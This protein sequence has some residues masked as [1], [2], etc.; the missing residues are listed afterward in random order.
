MNTGARYGEDE[1]RV[2]AA[3]K[4]AEFEKSFR[5]P[6][7]Y[8][9]KNH[10]IAGNHNAKA[11]VVVFSDP[12]CVFCIKNVP[13][14]IES[15]KGRD[16]IALYYYDFPLDMH[17]TAKTVIKAIVKAKK[18]GI[19]DVELKVYKANYEKFYNVYNTKEPQKAL[20]VFNKIFST[21]YTLE[22]IDTPEATEHIESDIFRGME[23]NVQGTPTVA[24]NG[25]FKDSRKNLKNFL[26]K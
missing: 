18:D 6:N 3:K 10:L 16:D 11:K 25:S 24:F 1:Q 20:D 22:Q 23:A 26:D 17:P 9:A 19:K 15:I 14:I 13:S 21:K 8:Y 12:L 2:K 4:R 7:D 5:L